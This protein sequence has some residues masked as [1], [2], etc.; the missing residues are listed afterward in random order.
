MQQKVL[1]VATLLHD[2]SLLIFDEPFRDL[3]PIN[4]D[5]LRDTI[6]ELRRDDQTMLFA[7]H[8]TEQVEQLCGDICLMAEGDVVLQGPL[9]ELLR[10]ATYE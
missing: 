5:L 1:F 3:A 7:S 8:R 4:V 2:L 9:R 10:W 6:L